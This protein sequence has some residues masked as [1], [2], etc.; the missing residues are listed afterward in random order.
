MDKQAALDELKR[1][2]EIGLRGGSPERIARHRARGHITVRERIDKLIDP[3]T[4]MEEGLLRQL[5]TPDG[6]EL[7]ANKLTG[8]GKIDGRTVIVRADDNTILAGSGNVRTR[9][10]DS[11]LT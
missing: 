3:G 8:Y 10:E 4:W 1:R 6:Q 7:A 9:P 11:T 2:Q 5:R